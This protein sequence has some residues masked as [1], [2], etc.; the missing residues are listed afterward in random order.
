MLTVATALYI[1]TCMYTVTPAISS[2]LMPVTVT[3]GI[4]PTLT[5]QHLDNVPPIPPANLPQESH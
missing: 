3:H 1:L 4:L 2:M 5:A